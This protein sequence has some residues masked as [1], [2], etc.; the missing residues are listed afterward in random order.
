MI[1]DTHVHLGKSNVFD[2]GISEENLLSSM[3]N[4]GVDACIV[5]PLPVMGKEVSKVHDDIYKLANNHKGKIFGLASINPHLPRKEVKYELER[6]IKE[7]GFVGIKCHTIGHSVNPL[8]EDGDFLFKMADDLGVPLNVHTGNGIVFAAPSLNIPMAKKYPDLKIVLAHSGMN[9]LLAEAFVAAGEC[10]NIYLETSWTPA[11]GIEG[12]IKS[13]G[14]KRILMGS[15]IY[16]ES[17]YNQAVELKKYEIINI[18]KEEKEDCLYKNA[19]KVFG[20]K[21]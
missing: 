5:Q 14:S 4:N 12:L 9:I 10:E 16:D 6:C 15:D 19:I 7:L 3:E 2:A 21:I 20:L 18:P 8:S 11:E 1:I 13:V 17:C